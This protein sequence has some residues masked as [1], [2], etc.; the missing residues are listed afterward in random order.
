M[1]RTMHW[2]VVPN[3]VHIV[4]HKPSDPGDQE[5]DE[6]L[7]S[8]GSV[9]KEVKG[10][11]VYSPTSGPTTTQRARG[12]ALFESIGFT[13]KIAVLTQSKMTARI[14]TALGWVFGKNI[15]AFSATMF[16]EATSSLG[17]D[18]REQA[19]ARKA[20]AVLAAQ[21]GVTIPNV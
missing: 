20:I 15:K 17:L 8:V 11:L 4:V 3:V 19:E 21:A 14:V 1:T 7:E 10:L 13:P 6:Y 9:A 2:T 5:W 18:D 16:N 12:T